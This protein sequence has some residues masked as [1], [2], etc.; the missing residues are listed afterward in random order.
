MIELYVIKMW[1]KKKPQDVGYVGDYT[2]IL[3]PD[4]SE[5]VTFLK[6]D[7]IQAS[8]EVKK[9]L[10][11]Y[12]SRRMAASIRDEIISAV[13]K[14]KPKAEAGSDIVP[15]M[16]TEEESQ[17]ILNKPEMFR[18]HPDDDEDETF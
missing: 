17:F 16:F 6:E 15:F 3:T 7:V 10:V 12:A 1:D 4:S 14:K 13:T 8:P 9:Q 2:T 11:A 5:R 18:K